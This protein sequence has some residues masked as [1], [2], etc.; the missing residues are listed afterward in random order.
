MEAQKI[1]EKSKAVEEKIRM[2]LIGFIRDAGT[3]EITVNVNQQFAQ[4]FPH[5][6]DMTSLTVNL[7]VKI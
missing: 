7:E 5:P 2:L 1:K 6:K 4:E 3:C